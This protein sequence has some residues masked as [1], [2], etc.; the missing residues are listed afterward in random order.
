MKGV[1]FTELLEMVEGTYGYETVDHIIQHSDLPSG[2]SYTAVGTY[3]H[4]ELVQLL[5]QLS[6]KTGT[7]I[8]A[9]M[10]RF[11]TYIF[12]H[13]AKGYP[14]FF[15]HSPDTFSFLSGIEDYIHV[16]VRKLYPDAELPTFEIQKRSENELSMIYRSE[17]RMA[18]FAAGLIEGC[19]NH[20]K[21]KLEVARKDLN[22]SGS[23]V[24]FL[25]RRG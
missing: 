4:T 25:I 18:D 20:Y 15:A 6:Q 8:P 16:E 5:I 3:D 7:P 1:V 13:F 19:A 12:D 24:E 21:E 11:G 14:Q 22:E 17:R 10:H 9:L 2:G 23:E